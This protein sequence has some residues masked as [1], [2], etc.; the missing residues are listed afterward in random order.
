VFPSHVDGRF[1]VVC[2][3]DELRRPAVIISAEAYDEDHSGWTIARKPEESK[4]ETQ[5]PQS[6]GGFSELGIYA[7]GK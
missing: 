2:Q 4:G 1:H 5:R 3:N 7:F 6:I